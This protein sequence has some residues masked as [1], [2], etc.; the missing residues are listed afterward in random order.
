[1]RKGQSYVEYAL[2][3]A[4]LLIALIIPLKRLAMA[5]AGAYTGMSSS[6]AA[7]QMQVGAPKTPSPS[8]APARGSF[9]REVQPAG[10]SSPAWFGL[11]WLEGLLVLGMVVAAALGLGALWIYYLERPGQETASGADNLF[12]RLKAHPKPSRRRVA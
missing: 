8:P 11:A 7:P 4:I 12:S 3:V 6:I 2:V 10:R 9:P 1:M 5:I